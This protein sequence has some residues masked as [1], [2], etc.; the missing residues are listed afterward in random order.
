[1]LSLFS[2]FLRVA[3]CCSAVLLAAVHHDNLASKGAYSMLPYYTIHTMPGVQ[4]LSLMMML[5]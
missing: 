5:I 3:A 2:C 4:L 1:M